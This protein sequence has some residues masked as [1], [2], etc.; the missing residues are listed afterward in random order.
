M[1][2]QGWGIV[3]E[4]LGSGLCKI[5]V[6]GTLYVGLS[7]FRDLFLIIAQKE[8]EKVSATVET[9]LYDFSFIL[10][11]LIVAVNGIFFIWIINSLNGTVAYLKNMNQTDKLRRH[12]RLRCLMVTSLLISFAWLAFWFLNAMMGVLRKDQISRGGI[13]GTVADPKLIFKSAL[14][15]G[16]SSIILI[17]NHPSGNLQPSQADISL[18]K[19]LKE[20]GKFLEIPVLDHIIVSDNSYFSFADE[21]MI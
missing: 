12:L 21:G 5:V 17:H 9:E 8:V 19:T 7:G 15:H 13:S 3:R 14:D 18:T 1:V 11:L 10:W 4:S 6:L 2:A 16:G 20:A